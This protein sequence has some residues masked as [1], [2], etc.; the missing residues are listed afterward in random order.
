[1]KWEFVRTIRYIASYRRIALSKR[2]LVRLQAGSWRDVIR[3]S[4][5]GARAFISPLAKMFDPTPIRLLREVHSAP[6]MYTTVAGI[7][8][9]NRVN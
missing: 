1:M 7:R 3:G 8:L 6:H 2:A 9:Y 4:A 5:D